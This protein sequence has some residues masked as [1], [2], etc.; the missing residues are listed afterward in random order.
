MY[1]KAVLLYYL[2][3]LTSSSTFNIISK[4]AVGFWGYE[5]SNFENDKMNKTLLGRKGPPVS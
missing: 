4:I 1:G 5:R 3:F 2:I